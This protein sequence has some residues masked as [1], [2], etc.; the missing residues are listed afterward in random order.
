VSIGVRG[1][2]ELLKLHGRHARVFWLH[3]A[4]TALCT[5]CWPLELARDRALQHGAFLSD[6]EQLRRGHGVCIVVGGC[7]F[8]FETKAG[9][10]A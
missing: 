1:F 6:D 3:S 5:E 9:H 10:A 8:W 7:T 2:V 4:A